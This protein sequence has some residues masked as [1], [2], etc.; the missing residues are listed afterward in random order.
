MVPKTIAVGMDVMRLGSALS[1]I[2]YNEGFR[3]IKLLFEKLGVVVGNRL[4]TTFRKFDNTRIHKSFKIHKDQMKRF[5]KKQQRSR[6]NQKKISIHGEGYKSGSY[7]IAQQQNN[8][9]DETSDNNCP[10]SQLLQSSPKI[11]NTPQSS[12]SK[13]L[14][15]LCGELRMTDWSDPGLERSHGQNRLGIL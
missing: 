15:K 8:S 13:E 2:R 10:P 4:E 5:D 1:V 14:C 3:G 11:A 9:D 6:S 7:S 12:S